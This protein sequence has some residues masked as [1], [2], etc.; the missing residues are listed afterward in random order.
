MVGE[1]VENREGGVEGEWRELLPARSVILQNLFVD[2]GG[3]WIAW[4]SH[5]NSLVNQNSEGKKRL[6]MAAFG[7]FK[8]ALMFCWLS[9]FGCR[10]NKR[11]RYSNLC[12]G[13][14]LYCASNWL[15]K[16]PDLSAVN[17][18]VGN[19]K[20]LH[21]LSSFA[22]LKVSSAR[23]DIKDQWDWLLCQFSKTSRTVQCKLTPLVPLDNLFYQ[24][25]SSSKPCRILTIKSPFR[26]I[27]TTFTWSPP[28]WRLQMKSI[29]FSEHTEIRPI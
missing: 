2:E 14:D 6:A 1:G 13:R 21:V 26:F 8:C 11:K 17:V 10:K 20:S 27:N 4:H 23:S 15:W 29:D 28:S 5:F 3:F 18:G 22:L 25:F 9:T 16:E 24:F 12:F 19:L 7:D